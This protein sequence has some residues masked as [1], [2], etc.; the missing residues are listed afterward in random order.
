MLQMERI[1]ASGEPYG[2]YM[3]A[4]QKKRPVAFKK[5]TQYK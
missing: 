2:Y 1:R 5:Y 4:I 3:P